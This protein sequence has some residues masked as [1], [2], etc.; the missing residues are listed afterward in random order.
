[1]FTEERLS[2]PLKE[3]SEIAAILSGSAISVRDLQFSNTALDI[4]SLNE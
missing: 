2:Q 4:Q 3:L 1:M